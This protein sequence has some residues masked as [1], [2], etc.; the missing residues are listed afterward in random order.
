MVVRADVGVCKMSSLPGWVLKMRAA[1][2]EA[3]EKHASTVSAI[4]SLQSNTA[5]L[6]IE[7]ERAQQFTRV[8]EMNKLE[9]ACAAS[10]NVS[11]AS[12]CPYIKLLAEQGD[13]IFTI[14]SFL[15]IREIFA[16]ESSAKLVSKSLLDTQGWHD[17]FRKHL[18]HRLNTWLE[19]PVFGCLSRVPADLI[20]AD[21]LDHMRS[22]HECL[23]FLRQMKEQRCVPKHKDISPKRLGSSD[24]GISHPL[25]MFEATH[26]GQIDRIMSRTETLDRDF[27][28][29]A[30]NALETVVRVTSYPNTLCDTMVK[31]SAATVLVSLLANE[32]QQLKHLACSALANIL[33]WES[34]RG[35]FSQQLDLCDGK[36]ALYSLLTSPSASINLAGNHKNGSNTA[37]VQGVC[38]SEASR[39][40]VNLFDSAHFSVPPPTYLGNGGRSGRSTKDPEPLMHDFIL[41]EYPRLRGWMFRY[42]TRSGELKD[43]F[44]CY[45]CFS[46]DGRMKGKGCDS[47]G[48]FLLNG[49]SEVD[50][51]VSAFKI[52]KGYL[53]QNELEEAS[54]WLLEGGEGAADNS[55]N[56]VHVRHYAYYTSGMSAHGRGDREGQFGLYG[57][58]EPASVG[59]H[60]SLSRGGVFCAQPIIH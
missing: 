29:V 40:L 60:F 43:E 16:L 51:N 18:P 4:R 33:C 27:R 22:S 12:K 54:S 42:F 55:S 32:A 59:S 9:A 39:A 34:S 26:A 49:T 30:L 28:T 57:V 35:I 1:I 13:I 52:A 31:E 36:K 7:I 38:N 45:L 58:W 37:P 14:C 24:G 10:D 8:A 11:D 2:K 5:V 17:L 6:T 44:I 20:R 48:F 50:I 56:I 3:S 25:P 47:I 15:S 19:D 41:S 46:S 53:S 23:T 21:V